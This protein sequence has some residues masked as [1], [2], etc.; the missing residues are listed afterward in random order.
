MKILFLPSASIELLDVI[1]FYDFHSP[2]L[3]VAF[4]KEFFEVLDFIQIF[5]NAWQKVGSHTRKC[6]LKKF[7]YIILYIADGEKLLISA[8]A[9]QHR[10]PKSYLR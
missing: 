1:N 8:I 9:H 10:H 6:V 7:P 3:G 2:E 5:P 4:Q